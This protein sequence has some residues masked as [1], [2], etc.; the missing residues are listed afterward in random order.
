MKNWF[1]KKTDEAKDRIADAPPL[2]LMIG[3]LKDSQRK[4]VVAYTKG[5]AEKYTSSYENVWFHIQ[6]DKRNER[7]LFEVQEG[8]DG[9]SVLRG[10]MEEL[11]MAS[12]VEIPLANQ[13]R[14]IVEDINGQ[15]HS[16][17]T[18][19]HELNEEDEQVE[20]KG[21]LRHVNTLAGDQRM[22]PLF[23]T[24][25]RLTK[26]GML[27][28]SLSLIASLFIAL[29]HIA[30]ESQV[31]DSSL[32][33]N[34]QIKAGERHMEDNPIPHFQK[35]KQEALETGGYVTRFYKEN[36]RWQWNIGR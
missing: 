4:D 36:G 27:F 2:F 29:L 31:F 28:F 12:S 35:A 34:T 25:H 11:A 30:I 26:I 24:N 15:F 7:F 10:V 21:V 17:V 9:R 20:M 23:A 32:L 3:S 13:K 19:E 22:T 33:I 1:R 5:L 18:P 16:F 6:E 14:V 8:G